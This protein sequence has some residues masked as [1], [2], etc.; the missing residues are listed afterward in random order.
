MLEVVSIGNIVKGDIILIEGME[1][2]GINIVTVEEVTYDGL[3]IPAELGG[4]DYTPPD[5]GEIVRIGS[6]GNAPTISILAPGMDLYL[7]TSA[8]PKK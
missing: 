6:I 3:I 5:D 4:L 7:N 2:N 8:Y 1:E